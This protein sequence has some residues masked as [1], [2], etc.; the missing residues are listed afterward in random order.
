MT[1][2]LI[3][4]MKLVLETLPVGSDTVYGQAITAASEYLAATEQSE[5]EYWQWRRKTKPWEETYIFRHEQFATTD[6]SE[7]RKLYTHP[8]QQPKAEPV[9]QMLLD[10]IKH[11]NQ[12]IEMHEEMDRVTAAIHAAE[13]AP[14][15]AELTDDELKHLVSLVPNYW[16]D[17]DDTYAMRVARAVLAAQKG[18]A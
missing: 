8:A 13:Q 4:R 16:G 5:P 3:K 17:K 7:V 2:A 6:D 10:E 15:P 1:R 18:K 14:Q 11:L 9:N 12:V